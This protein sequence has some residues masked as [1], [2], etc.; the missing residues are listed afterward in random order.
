M[1]LRG[2]C[3]PGVNGASSVHAR[4][5]SLVAAG[6]PV[7]EGIQWRDVRAIYPFPI[8]RDETSSFR[9]DLAK[10]K[11]TY[12]SIQNLLVATLLPLS[13]AQNPAT[14]PSDAHP[15]PRSILS[16]RTNAIARTDLATN[17]R[18]PA[19]SSPFHSRDGHLPRLQSAH[20]GM[21]WRRLGERRAVERGPVSGIR[22]R[23]RNWCP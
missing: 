17:R 4:N 2:T 3:D 19:A 18:D 21:P 12:Q 23:S 5:V 20:P 9:L 15:S 10:A 6:Y 14:P 13:D 22:N 11:L 8:F 7:A 16:I 1:C